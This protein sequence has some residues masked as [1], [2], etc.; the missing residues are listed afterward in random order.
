MTDRTVR[1]RLDLDNAGARRG[2]A[3]SE[4]DFRQIAQAAVAAGAEQQNAFQRAATVSSAAMERTA[5]VARASGRATQE[6]V[7][8]T[9]A[10]MSRLALAAEE[11][12]ATF[13]S[14][15][16]VSARALA[17]LSTSAAAAA[18]SVVA[19]EARMSEATAASAAGIR[20]SLAVRLAA[21]EALMSQQAALAASTSA[22]AT[23]QAGA[24]TRMATAGDRAEKAFSA[25][26][27]TGFLMLAMF[28]AAAISAARFEKAMSGVEA[29]AGAT[30]QEMGQLREAALEAGRTTAFT[31]S[32]A[33]EAEGELARAGVSVADILGGAL[34]GALSLAAAGQLS[35]AEAS[36][37]AAQSMNTFGL[38]GQDVA[39][40]ADV[41]AAGANKS[42]ADV[43]GLGEAMRMG[44]L[45]AHQTGLSFEDTVGT[46]SAFADHALIG[47]DAG[48]SL[49]TMLQRLTPQSTEAANMM[50]QL[51]F[52]AYDAQGRF[53]GLDQLA[54]RLHDSFANL[55]PEAR[56]SAMGVIFGSDA[57]RAATI[58][59]EQ[60]AGGIQTYRDAVN[61]NGAAARMAA[62]QLDNLSGDLEA[63]KGSLEVALIQ[64]GTA[65]NGVLREMVQ[66]VT[67]VVNAYSS[68]PSWAQNSAIGI[69]AI[70]GALAVAAGGFMLVLPRI[71]AFQ[72]SLITLS[73][74]MPR[75][76]SAATGTMSVLTGPWG[77][78]IGVAVAA[79]TVFGLAQGN[80]KEK[81]QSLTEAV[82]ADGAAIGANAKAWLAHELETRGALA[83]A[84]DLGVSTTDLTDAILGNSNAVDRV[85][86]QLASYRDTASEVASAGDGAAGS[87]EDWSKSLVKVDDALKGMSPELNTAVDAAKREAE[88]SGAAADS[89]SKFGGA[90]AKTADDVKDVR[91]EVDK[92]VD[93]LNA[94]NG[95]NISSAQ[96]AIGLQSSF[97]DLSKAVKDNGV[98]LDISTEKGRAV[99]AAML[100][101]AEAAQKHAEAVA[102]QT[103]SADQANIVFAQDVAALKR[104]MEQAGFTKAQIDSLTQAYAQV[105]PTKETKVTDPGAL[106]TIADMERAR[107]AVENVP[108]GK[109]VTMKALTKDAEQGLQSLGFQVEHMKDGTVKV[110]VPTS[111][112]FNSTSAIQSYVNGL[113]GKVV[114]IT[115]EY[116][117]VQRNPGLALPENRQANGGITGYAWGGITA[118]AGGLDTRQAGFSSQA[119]L[120]AE[121]GREAYIPMDPAKRGRST[122]LLSQ[123]AGEFG[124]QLLPAARDLIPA[125]ALAGPAGGGARGGGDRTTNI[126]LNGAKQSIEEQLADLQRHI[127]FVS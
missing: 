54:A 58:L 37:V 95:T 29:V 91:T 57:V 6:S 76:A 116:T 36:V 103:G 125:R 51:G 59:Y 119:I 66:W 74:T 115:V 61:D 105:P 93:R 45:L 72:S 23:A 77:A 40:V 71:A 100:D 47:S 65:A 60:G 30:K 3:E 84:K 55:T 52:S 107:Q 118:A 127:E 42:A 68:L 10:S 111:D 27:T 87:Q 123:V 113:K 81:T 102:K 19:S 88:A 31:A 80:A 32:Q 38:R 89:T 50:S 98:T 41:L 12:P 48:T 17:E 101:A 79:L 53:V 63:F 83:A 62:V 126:T 1:V 110:T 26:R 85:N 70:G 7:L 117:N 90:A 120:W 99:K 75:L 15:A 35:L 122:Q 22:S 78:A 21:G 34:R 64:S 16:S 96:A 92:L 73:T 124:L 8:A 67:K 97:F 112:A 121:A 28:A 43:H 2:A 109:S 114:P 86:T 39:H 9:S 20:Q 11:V 49:K 33:A 82:K 25:V 4:R 69:L 104:V 24:F 46:L 14:A 94:L 5:A 44:G 18:S 56:N 108:A 13:S 106:Q